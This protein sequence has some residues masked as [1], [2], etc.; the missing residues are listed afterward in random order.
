MCV[1]VYD[2]CASRRTRRD[3]LK[4]HRNEARATVNANILAVIHAN[5]H[6]AVA[7]SHYVR[8]HVNTQSAYS[9][10]PTEQG[11]LEQPR[12]APVACKFVSMIEKRAHPAAGS[13]WRGEVA[14]DALSD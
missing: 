5:T 11:L 6:V 10:S 7:R 8:C 2:V 9:A 13:D 12:A 14:T 3:C 1:C 4:N